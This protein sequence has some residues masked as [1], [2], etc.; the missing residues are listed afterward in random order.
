MTIAP[1]VK[2]KLVKD[3]QRHETDSGSPEVQVAVLSARVAE[4]QDHLKGHPKDH[5][6]RRGLVMMVGKR[7]R[8]LKYL[9]TLNREAYQSLIKRL[10]LRK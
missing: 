3:Y 4:L 10:G 1:E 6:S 7:N 9:A 2:Q 8:L 5:G